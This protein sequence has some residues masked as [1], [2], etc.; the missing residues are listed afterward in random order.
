MGG[1]L[2]ATAVVLSAST[3]MLWGSFLGGSVPVGLVF[4]YAFGYLL[5]TVERQEG[6]PTPPGRPAPVVEE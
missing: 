5:L 1:L 3:V 2:L 6:S 4:L